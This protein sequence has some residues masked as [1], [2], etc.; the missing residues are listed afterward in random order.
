MLMMG[1]GST[2]GGSSVH[3]PSSWNR[4]R[5]P[6]KS[7]RLGLPKWC[8]CGYWPI[9]RWSGTDSN[10]N[11]PFYDSPNYNADSENDE[12]V[13]KSE[14]SGDDY[15]V[16]VNFDWR[17]WRLEEDVRMQKVITQL[18]VLVVSVLIVLIV[19]LYCK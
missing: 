12:H 15:Q 6:S 8:S 3:S 10:P 13:D 7:I 1:G 5:T 16:K 17:L 18:L 2:A 14:S 19:I 9:L 11:K 4:T